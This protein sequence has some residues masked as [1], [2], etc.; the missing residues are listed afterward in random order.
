[1]SD[2]FKTCCLS[3]RR[4]SERREDAMSNGLEAVRRMFKAI[5]SGDL[6]D[7]DRYISQDYL[8]HE[9]ND[10]GRSSK[11]G[12]EE[13][14]ETAGWLRQTFSDLRFEDVDVIASGDRVVIVTYMSGIQTGQ[15]LGIP[16]ANRAFRQRQV[17][18]FRIDAAG[19]VAEH[20]AVRDDLGLRRQLAT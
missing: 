1:M 17:H 20:L 13:F 9:S 18:I 15:F 3:S 6:H 10:D 7:V 2:S 8:N 5:E 19:K 14:R 16:P 11:R 12:P 4:I